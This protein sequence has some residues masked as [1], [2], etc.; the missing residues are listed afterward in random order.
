[1]LI[2]HWQVSQLISYFNF[3]ALVE[4]VFDQEKKCAD[5]FDRFGAD[6]YEIANEAVDASTG[7]EH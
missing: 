5:L 1:M 3:G 6:V 7:F 4:A 2:L